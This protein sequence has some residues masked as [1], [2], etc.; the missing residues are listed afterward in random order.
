MH[1][2]FEEIVDKYPDNIAVI[3]DNQKL[4]YSELNQKANQVARILRN[5]GVKSDVIVGMLVDR[6]IEMI[7]GILAILKAGGAYLPIDPDYPMDRIDFTL[8]DSGTNILLTTNNL[9]NG[10]K[11]DKEIISLD[12][13]SLYQGDCSNLENINNFSDLSYIIYTSGTTGRPKG[14]MIEH[15]NVVRLLFNDKC[16]F[17]FDS[18]DI[19]TMFH[20]YC[21]DFSVWEMYGALLYGGKLVVI[22]KMIA[23]NPL[24]YLE[25][26]SFNI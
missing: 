21:F 12:D 8:E 1:S 26:T 19:W 25:L 3:Y 2:I 24:Q 17:D 5:N 20:S 16:L 14:V 15:R 18:N 13:N 23:R 4:T 11:F 22:P 10:I 7:I 6:S 9:V